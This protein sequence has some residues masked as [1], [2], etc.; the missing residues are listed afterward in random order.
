MADQC[1]RNCDP[2]E[3]EARS[4]SRM[5]DSGR[6]TEQVANALR[7]DSYNMSPRDF[8][9]LVG[10]MSQTERKNQGDDIYQDRNGNVIIDTGR[11]DIVVATRDFD[12]QN[13][14]NGQARHD[15]RYGNNGRGNNRDAITDGVVNS[16]IGAVTGGIINGEKG[17]I[18]GGAA[19]VANVV[20]D[21]VGGPNNRDEVTDVVVKGAIGA[22]IGAVIDGKRG[23][24]SG[25]AGS[26]A[27]SVIDKIF[28]KRQ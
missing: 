10:L 22:G 11:Q 14:N 9:R 24:V 8:S 7:E 25:A 3:A 20:V 19:G 4:L 16:A 23:A 26:G 12:M 1:N 2:V 28:N 13:R 17:A 5:L 18:A 6:Q 27:A 15:G 21:R